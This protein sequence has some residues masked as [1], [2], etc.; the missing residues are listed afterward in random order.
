MQR[1]NRTPLQ[2]RLLAYLVTT[3][4]C[5]A[6]WLSSPPRLFAHAAEVPIAVHHDALGQPELHVLPS[7]ELAHTAD[8]H[9]DSDGTDGYAP[10]FALFDRSL[11]GRQAAEV[12][13]LA[14]NE[15]TEMDI[16]PGATVNFVYERSQS[17]FRRSDDV[18][19]EALE[20]RGADN[21]SGEE[22]DTERG[23]AE[24]RKRQA[25]RRIWLSATTC[26]QPMP[27]NVTTASQNHP[28]LTMYVST[29]TK[30]QKPGP[31]STGNLATNVTGVPFDDGYAS[32]EVQADSDVYI[33]IAAPKL[34]KDWFGSWHF[35]V[36]ASTD[37]LYHS[38]NDSNPFLFM[39]DT[40]SESALFITYDLGTSNDT[41]EVDKWRDEN[42]F[43]MYAFPADAWTPIT[44]MEH[45]YCALKEQF[46]ANTTK[47]FTIATSITTKF[48]GD[49]PNAQFHVQNLDTATTY[50]GFVVVAGRQEPFELPGV[51]TVRG[52]GQVFQQFEWTTKAGQ[53]SLIVSS[54]RSGIKVL[55]HPTR[56]FLPSPLRPRLL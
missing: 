2:S 25:G 51:G 39:V 53:L 38:Y 9:L 7:G 52:G 43:S 8:D 17:R 56:R 32:F 16:G 18:P 31:D 5:L 3:C 24:L 26:R 27:V 44:G 47:N 29:S 21:A 1:L 6:L 49:L 30:N 13:K 54:C 20:A 12:N 37:G 42:P 11:V 14:N 40:D 35:E 34:D 23:G 50:N 41:Q 33:G 22:V 45:S 4:L 15:K 55:I 10:D 36:A 19:L 46:N 48:G 28:Q